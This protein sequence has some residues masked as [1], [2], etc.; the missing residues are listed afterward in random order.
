[1]SD[2]SYHH[3]NLDFRQTRWRE[4]LIIDQSTTGERGVMPPRTETAMMDET[5]AE[6]LVPQALRRQKPPRL[7]E[8]SQPYVL[9]HYSRLSQMVLGNNVS[10][11]TGLATATMKY[12]PCVHES[13]VRLPTVAE[14]HPLQDADSLQGILEIIWRCAE[15]LKE[16]SGM[17]HFSLQPGGG[18]QAIFANALIIKRFHQ[19]RGQANTRTEVISTLNSHPANA[20][21]AATA[22]F[23]VIHLPPGPQGYPETDAL[24]AAVSERT[25][26]LL[27][28]NP[29]D[30]GIFNPNIADWVRILHDAGALCAYDQANANGIVGITRARDTGFDLCH[31]NL[32]KTFSVPHGSYGGGC[33]ALGVRE[34]LAPYL[35]KPVVVYDGTKY[36]IDYDRPQSIGTVRAFLGNIQAVVKAYA[37]MMAHGAEGI[38]QVAETAVLNNNYLA[39]K[40]CQIRGASISYPDNTTHRIEQTR[41]SWKQLHEETGIDTEDIRNRV[42]DFGIQTYWPSHHPYTIPQPFSLEPTE[43]VSKVDM[44]ELA[45]VFDYVAEEAYTNPDMIRTAPHNSTCVQLHPDAFDNPPITWRK[46]R[47]IDEP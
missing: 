39:K 21:A 25:A 33:G 23:K 35:P 37:W 16:I 28:T 8:L 46:Y 15:M 18:A 45:E 17:C 41:F 42:I 5:S 29:E 47:V 40:I 6:S 31:F 1:M 12:S 2:K 30:T 43:S 22:G 20:A 38:R 9:R 3:I 26:A 36:A 13:L 27:T 34:D 44:D 14:L 4:K 11:N 19:D 24:R 7:P 10:N 32:H